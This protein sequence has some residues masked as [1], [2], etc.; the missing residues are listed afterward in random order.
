[1]PMI[2]TGSG[3]K[4]PRAGSGLLRKNGTDNFKA[5]DEFRPF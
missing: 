5:W 1:M 4:T 3:R 2:K